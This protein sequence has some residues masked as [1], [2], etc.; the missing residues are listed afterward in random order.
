M[1]RIPR[2]P[3]LRPQRFI[4]PVAIGVWLWLLVAE[5]VGAHQM[6][7]VLAGTDWGSVVG[8]LAV[9]QAALLGQGI[10]VWGGVTTPLPVGVLLRTASAMSFAELIGGPV[11]SAATSV[12]L[13][14]ERGLSPAAAYSSGVLSSV[15]GVVVPLVL[16]I[17]FVP[18]AASKLHLAAAGPSGSDAALLQ[19]LLLV[20]VAAG[21]LGG[22][23][24]V[25]PRVRHALASRTRPQFSSAWSNIYDVTAHAGPVVRLL[26]GPALTQLLFASGLGLC[27]HAVGAST[28]FGALVLV[29]CAVSVLGGITPVPGGMGVVEA[30]YI[31]GLTFAGVPQDL[32]AVATLLF[33][34]CTAYLPALW[35]WP[36][37][38]RLREG[39]GSPAA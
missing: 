31:S 18:F 8:A 12:A 1:V 9:T 37:L 2:I 22:V 20:V 21:L 7:T 16:G 38:V 24:Y 17:V 26:A 5:L 14:R 4:V 29:C 23:F 19:V 11:A 6:R 35:G 3:R 28:N 36:A 25:V 30:T 39:E 27:V 33:R 15:A 10:A 34:S 32:A 13:F